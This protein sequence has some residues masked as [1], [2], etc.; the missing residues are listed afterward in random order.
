MTKTI[1]ELQERLASTVEAL[2]LVEERAVAG[3][4]ALE[5]MH[6]I[7]NP[8]EALGNLTFLAAEEADHPE[9]VRKYLSLAAEQMATLTHIASQTLGIARISNVPKPIDLVT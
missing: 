9:K 4:L 7:K 3:R 6:E 8:L 1:S 5:V 2:R